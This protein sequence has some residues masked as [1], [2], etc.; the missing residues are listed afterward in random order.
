MIKEKKVKYRFNSVL[1]PNS[2]APLNN[3]RLL[4][5][6]IIGKN[7]LFVCL[8]ENT[9]MPISISNCDICWNQD[10]NFLEW[11]QNE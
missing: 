3:K 6:I 11:L 1:D 9:Y 10:C 7:Y 2:L 8:L 5:I 4:L